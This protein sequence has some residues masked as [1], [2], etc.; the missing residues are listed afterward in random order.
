VIIA[1]GVFVVFFLA[2]LGA[3]WAFVVRPEERARGIVRG[4][5]TPKQSLKTSVHRELLKQQWCGR[6]APEIL[7]VSATVSYTWSRSKAKAALGKPC[8]S[9][10]DPI[11]EFSIRGNPVRSYQAF[12]VTVNTTMLGRG[13]QFSILHTGTGET[14]GPVDVDSF[15]EY[16]APSV[17]GTPIV[18]PPLSRIRVVP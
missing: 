12:R 11:T 5:L 18:P 8:S 4:R 16:L 9:D 1:L 14:G 2:I 10:T 7:Q 15:Q 6:K 3:Y 13:A 17:T